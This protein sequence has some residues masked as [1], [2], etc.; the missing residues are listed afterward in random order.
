MNFESQLVRWFFYYAAGTEN[1]STL[2]ELLRII[3]GGHEGRNP[4]KHSRQKKQEERGGC[5][6]SHGV[7]HA[8]ERGFFL[9][10]L[11]SR[12]CDIICFWQYI[13]LWAYECHAGIR[14]FY[15]EGTTDWIKIMSY[16][17]PDWMT[18]KCCSGVLFFFFVLKEHPP[19]GFDEYYF[20]K[21]EHL[22]ILLQMFED[23]G[24]EMSL[25]QAN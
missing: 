10:H 13:Q 16:L 24:G 18:R 4:H 17:S 11:Y 7:D 25:E 3:S 5:F 9:F 20:S 19:Y 8:A 21:Q 22:R 2:C 12:R 6:A 1:L 14:P 23:C 15:M